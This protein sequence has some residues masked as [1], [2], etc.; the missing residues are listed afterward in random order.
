LKGMLGK[1]VGSVSG[2]FVYLY[3]YRDIY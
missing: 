2:K 3:C 1:V